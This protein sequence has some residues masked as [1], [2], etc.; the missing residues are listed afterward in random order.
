MF[1]FAL[2]LV[3]ILLPLGVV[4]AQDAA[5]LV[6]IKVTDPIAAETKSTQTPN[7]GEFTVYRSNAT[8]LV[9]LTV[10]YK[11]DGTAT[12]GVDYRKL[13]GQVVIPGGAP[14]AKIVVLPIDDNLVEKTETV[15]VQLTSVCTPTFCV[16]NPSDP[17][18]VY[19]YD[20]D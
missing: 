20:N 8:S 14:S 11:I 9:A 12:N 5:P 17:V 4:A 1:F 19:I 15:V 13:T 10:N 7:P 16:I 6:T 2:C 3:T 18:T